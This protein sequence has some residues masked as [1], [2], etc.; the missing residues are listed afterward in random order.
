MQSKGAFLFLSLS[1]LIIEKLAYI[2]YS[3]HQRSEF[4]W[5]AADIINIHYY[6]FVGHC[7]AFCGLKWRIWRA[8]MYFSPLKYTNKKWESNNRTHFKVCWRFL[9]ALVKKNFIQSV[10]LSF[11]SVFIFSMPSKVI[12]ILRVGRL[13]VSEDVRVSLPYCFG[14]KFKISCPCVFS[15]WPNV[16]NAKWD[17]VSIAI[18]PLQKGKRSVRAHIQIQR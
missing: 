2:E 3:Y 1:M 6:H 14:W 10:L 7:G 5:A 18:F 9:T 16:I 12:L 8:K 11:F 13:C 17:W 15:L 4:I